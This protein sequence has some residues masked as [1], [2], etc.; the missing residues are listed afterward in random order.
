MEFNNLKRQYKILKKE[1][2]EHIAEIMADARFLN[3]EEIKE[4]EKN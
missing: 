3:G 4:L 1:I 2:D